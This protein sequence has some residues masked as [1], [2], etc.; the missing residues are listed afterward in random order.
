MRPTLVFDSEVYPNWTLFLF[1]NVETGVLEGFEHPMN[2]PRLREIV[3]T[4][5]LVTFNG[6]GYDIP[7]LMLALKGATAAQL[8]H[9]SDRIIIQHCKPWN[10]KKEF[11]VVLDPPE[12][13]HIDLMEVAP[14]TGS[15]KAYAGR[16]HAYSLQDLPIEPSTHVSPE[17]IEILRQ[18]CANDLKSTEQLYL[19]LKKSIELR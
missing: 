3:R 2:L 6:L 7:I 16:L 9:A 1:R 17:Q 8:K 15:L 19:A 5:R 4:S 13:D 12:L 11:N 10:F 18:Y 14:L